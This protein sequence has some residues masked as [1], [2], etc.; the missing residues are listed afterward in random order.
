MKL[1]WKHNNER[2][3]IIAE[4]NELEWEKILFGVAG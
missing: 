4:V 2:F 1:L 3:I